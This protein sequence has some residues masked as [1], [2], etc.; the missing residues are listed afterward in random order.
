[1]AGC[2]GDAEHREQKREQDRP[3]EHLCSIAARRSTQSKNY[4]QS[5]APIFK[6]GLGGGPRRGPRRRGEPSSPHPRRPDA[7]E[8]TPGN[9]PGQGHSLRVPVEPLP[10]FCF[11][12]RNGDHFGHAKHYPV[13]HLTLAQ[14]NVIAH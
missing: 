5:R 14:V 2:D 10:G 4:R 11:F 7:E 6:R 3:A 13:S 1:M 8:T 12:D 9:S